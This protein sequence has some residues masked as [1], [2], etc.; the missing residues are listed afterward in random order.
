MPN[1]RRKVRY[2]NSNSQTVFVL[3]LFYRPTP[4]GRPLSG[5]S[6]DADK[7][8]LIILRWIYTQGLLLFI[9]IV[10]NRPSDRCPARIRMRIKV[11]KSF[12]NRFYATMPF[13]LS[14]SSEAVRATVDR[15]GFGCGIMIKISWNKFTHKVCFYFIL[16]SDTVRATAIRLEFGCEFVR[17]EC[18]CSF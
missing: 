4:S 16:S 10:R 13:I 18:G 12:W 5:S 3:I 2:N 14:V 8:E 11:N 9:S 15:L 1:F 7:I 6:S 17:L